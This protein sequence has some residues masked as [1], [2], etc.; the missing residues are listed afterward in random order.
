LDGGKTAQVFFGFANPTGSS[1]YAKVPDK[2]EVVLV[3]NVT[4]QG[5]K[6][7]LLDLR[8]RSLLKFNEFGADTLSLKNSHGAFTLKRVDNVWEIKE[9]VATRAEAP[10]VSAILNALSFTKV[11]DFV[12]YNLPTEAEMGFDKPL[13][14]VTVTDSKGG[15][16]AAKEAQ[17]TTHQL[18]IGARHKA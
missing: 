13:I 7:E 4:H 3:P 14:A 1:I 8:E 9:P 12:D 5:I 17:G 18:L 16:G 2:K 10:E 15:D 6:K 11:N